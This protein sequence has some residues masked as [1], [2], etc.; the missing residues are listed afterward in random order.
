MDPNAL[1]KQGFSLIEYKGPLDSH[2]KTSLPL[3]SFDGMIYLCIRE[4]DIDKIKKYRNLMSYQIK[5]E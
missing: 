1:K 3:L 2:Y 5:K 4:K